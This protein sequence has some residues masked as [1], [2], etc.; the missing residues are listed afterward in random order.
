M[1]I[2]TSNTPMRKSRRMA[3]RSMVSTSEWS[4]YRELFNVDCIDEHVTAG[5]GVREIAVKA[6]CADGSNNLTLITVTVL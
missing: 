5:P 4:S 2:N 6:W 1:P 3:M